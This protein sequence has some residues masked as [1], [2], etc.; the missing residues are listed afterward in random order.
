MYHCCSLRDAAYCMCA[1]GIELSADLGG[2]GSRKLLGI[3]RGKNIM[4]PA[5]LQRQRQ[6]AN[7]AAAAAAAS[8][9]RAAVAA[10]AAAASV[11]CSGGASAASAA[12]AAG[13]GASF[14]ASAASAAGELYALAWRDA[15]GFR[16]H[17]KVL[18]EFLMVERR[19]RI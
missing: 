14:A 3:T 11:G 9:K 15:V 4:S 19:D 8:A 2:N 7:A 16:C 5:Q 10:V 17:A 18:D 13:G 12:S 1:G 6:Q